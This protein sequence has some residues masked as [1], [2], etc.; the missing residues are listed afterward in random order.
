[1]SKGR[2]VEDAFKEILIVWDTDRRM[3]VL[4]KDLQVRP[5]SDFFIGLGL[6]LLL[7]V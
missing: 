6:P 5:R 7:G 2:V 1:M 3:I 4:L